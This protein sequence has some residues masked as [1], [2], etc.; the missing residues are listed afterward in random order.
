MVWLDG[1]SPKWKVLVII[2]LF[3]IVY[4]KNL[5]Y[6]RNN[7][8]KI[9][10]INY[11]WL[12][13]RIIIKSHDSWLIIYTQWLVVNHRGGWTSGHRLTLN[14]LRGE[15]LRF[16]SS[17]WEI[18]LCSQL[19]FISILDGIGCTAMAHPNFLFLQTLA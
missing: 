16:E 19:M 14:G 17:T 5:I 1:L 7:G 12:I 11:P 2:F 10:P 18:T 13:K 15:G 4:Y 6:D 9:G 3:W 8:W